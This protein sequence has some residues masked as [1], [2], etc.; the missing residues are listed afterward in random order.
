MPDRFEHFDRDDFIV[1]VRLVAIVLNFD[2][3][4]V[5]DFQ[6]SHSRARF[7]GLLFGQRQPSDFTPNFCRQANG[8]LAPPAANFENLIGFLKVEAS[9]HG[10]DFIV[11][12]LLEVNFFLLER[13]F[14]VAIHEKLINV[15]VIVAVQLRGRSVRVLHV[16]RGRIQQRVV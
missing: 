4:Q 6:F 3:N 10:V 15:H 7:C 2:F 12:R 14:S 8:E 11:L 1:H 13:H 5:R 9:N 16:H